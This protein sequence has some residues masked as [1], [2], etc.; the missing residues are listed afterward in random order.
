MRKT[1]P[2][3]PT[4]KKYWISFLRVIKSMYKDVFQRR[5]RTPF[6]HVDNGSTIRSNWKKAPTK[7]GALVIVPSKNAEELEAAKQYL[8]DNLNKGFSLC[9]SHSHGACQVGNYGFVLI[10]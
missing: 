10:T 4:S 3:I 9:L 7:T 8:I 5:N 2:P 6:H 1:E